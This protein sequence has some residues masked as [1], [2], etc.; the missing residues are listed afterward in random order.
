MAANAQAIKRVTK[1][2]KEI[3]KEPPANCS[4][5]PE[6]Y[7]PY[8]F[9]SALWC[10]NKR[11]PTLTHFTFVTVF[12]SD[13]IFSWKATIM[14]PPG[15]PY[16]GGVFF[17]KINF[18]QE[19]PF[20]PPKVKFETKVYHCNV[21][22]T[23]EI[24]MDILKDNWSPALTI[25]KVLLSI[26]SLRTE[27]NPAEPLMAEIAALYQSN[28]AEHDKVSFSLAF[29]VFALLSCVCCSIVLSAW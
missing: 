24:C 13:D 11:G 26:S 14:G 23:G 17:L 28:R 25:S 19:Y 27:P 18:P 2:H 3:L 22:A 21:N 20:K 6:G 1:E 29:D 4:A 10:G 15:S 9:A 7:D 8:R 5:G 12:I 16:E